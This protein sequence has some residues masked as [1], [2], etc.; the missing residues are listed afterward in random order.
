MDHEYW[1][2]LCQD[3]GEKVFT[4]IKK[5]SGKDERKKILKIGFSGD[6][7][8]LLDDLAEKLIFNHFKSTGKSFEFV[9][10]EIGRKTVGDKPEVMIVVDPL[11][12]SNNASFGIPLFS[13][14]ISIGDLSGKIKGVEVG[15]VKNL[16]NGDNYHAIKG[17]GAFKN[18][19]RIHVIEERNKC[20]LVDIAKNRKESFG[21]IV[22]LGEKSRAVRMLGSGCLSMCFFAEGLAD[23]CIALGGKRTIDATASQLIVREAEGLVKDLEGKDF[24]DYEIGFNMNVNYVATPNEDIYSEVISLLS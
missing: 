12:G 19:K 7:T 21:R 8:L 4:E 20:F 1:L 5:H 18:G 22:R 2:K 17:K 3:V 6:K 11:D 24:T 14:S 16:V 23:A 9:S 10:E 15:Y 13:T